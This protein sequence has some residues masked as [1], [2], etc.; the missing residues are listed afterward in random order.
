[1]GFIIILVC[2]TETGEISE[3][4]LLKARL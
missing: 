1:M 3:T 4:K 2:S